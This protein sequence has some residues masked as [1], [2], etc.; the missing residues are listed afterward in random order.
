MGSHRSAFK[1]DDAIRD[2]NVSIERLPVGVDRVMHESMP[3]V[4]GTF[5]KMYK[6][7]SDDAVEGK[8]TL[9]LA[10]KIKVAANSCTSK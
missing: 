3:K 10:N 1:L 8:T 9:L 7:H 4:S 6:E 2:V 5:H